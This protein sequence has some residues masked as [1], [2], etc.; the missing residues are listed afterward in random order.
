[1]ELDAPVSWELIGWILS[2]HSFIKVLKPP[3]LIHEM[4]KR[5]RDALRQY[6]G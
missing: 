1:M 3:A 5:L 6:E 4:K 2:W